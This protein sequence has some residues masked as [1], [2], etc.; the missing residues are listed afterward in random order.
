MTARA[1][2][3]GIAS[4]RYARHRAGLARCAIHDRGVE[5]VAAVGGEHR[6]ASGVEQRIVLEHA[7]RGFD[8][9][10]ARTATAQHLRPG[11]DAP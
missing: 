9:I 6:T 3:I 8:G 4:A 10:E 5:L 1:R 11:I 2:L 7:D